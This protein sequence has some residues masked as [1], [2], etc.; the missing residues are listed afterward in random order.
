M[1]ATPSDRNRPPKPRPPREG[2]TP[3]FDPVR[4]ERTPIDPQLFTEESVVQ[5][6][7]PTEADCLTV[8]RNIG[9]GEPGIEELGDIDGLLPC[10]WDTCAWYQDKHRH[11]KEWGIYIEGDCIKRAA[12]RF[13]RFI[14]SVPAATDPSELFNRLCQAALLSY[15]Y[16]EHYHY[17]VE[18]LAY[19]LE[20]CTGRDCYVPYSEK[21]YELL[22]KNAKKFPAGKCKNYEKGWDPDEQIEESLANAYS[23][24]KMGLRQSL[25]GKISPLVV[26]A[27]RRAMLWQFKFDPP[28]YRMALRYLT[29]ARFLEGE[30]L[31]KHRVYRA[32]LVSAKE[33]KSGELPIVCADGCQDEP[34][35]V[36]MVNDRCGGSKTSVTPV[37]EDLTASHG[38]A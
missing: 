8:C 20:K 24:S 26:G 13:A 7:R 17:L 12:K 35:K 2:H 9:R 36:W 32:D 22:K 11:P 38:P 28:G 27:V 25:R 19:C 29:R 34:V 16:H 6:F 30:K 18:Q 1:N 14:Q 23:Y 31:L 3:R 21:V 15:Y 37:L 33:A 5:D 4:H 10:E